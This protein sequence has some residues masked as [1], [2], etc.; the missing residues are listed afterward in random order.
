MSYIGDPAIQGVMNGWNNYITGS[1]AITIFFVII[2]L[3]VLA[4]VFRVDTALILIFLIPFCL[5][6]F[7]YGV[8][9]SL[10][11]TI[12][13]IVGFFVGLLLLWLKRN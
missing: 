9:G 1:F 7:A 8:G 4:M 2:F 11:G 10:T 6:A 3:I 13:V 12:I 5:V